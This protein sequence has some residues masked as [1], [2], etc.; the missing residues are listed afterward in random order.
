MPLST[1]QYNAFLSHNS[2]DK[3]LVE[4]IAQKLLNEE[5]LQ[6]F[7]D[8]W[9][10][11]PGE[12]WQEALEEALN[13]SAT[14]VVFLGPNTISPWQHEEM[15]SSLAKRV[16]NKLLRV[17]P[18]K[19]PKAVKEAKESEVPPFLQRLTW[20]YFENIDDKEAFHRL[21]CGIKGI[22]P[23]PSADQGYNP[24]TVNP[25]R[26]LEVFR[27]ADARYFFGRE[28]TIQRLKDHLDNYNFL[29]VIGPSGS[30]KSSIVQAG[31]IA[32]LRSVDLLISL[33]TPTSHPLVELTM[34]VR[35]LTGEAYD[36]LYKKIANPEGGKELFA[37]SRD[38]TDAGKREHKKAWGEITN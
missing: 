28:A 21:V 19:L 4:Q 24:Q 23:G 32:Q 16:E 2:K 9:N 38:I 22:P 36:S 11:I 37:I 29:A 34:A 31:L 13:Q 10:L 27:E 25:F 18:V 17:I 30:G 26:G 5:H 15:R 14:C 35:R 33:F 12:L 8:K 3:P 7:L 1:N 6:V 20:V